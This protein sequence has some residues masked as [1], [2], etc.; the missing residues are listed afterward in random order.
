MP[1]RYP[2][3]LATVAVNGTSAPVSMEG[4]RRHARGEQ[5][6]SALAH[7]SLA[8]LRAELRS[9]EQVVHDLTT[10]RQAL[11][12]EMESIDR[13]LTALSGPDPQL[14]GPRRPR[15][16]DTLVTA[17]TKLLAGRTMSVAEATDAVQQA[18]YQ[19][20]SRHFRTQVNIALIRSGKF[21]RTGRGT[22]T[23]RATEAEG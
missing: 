14:S 13:Q 17:L 23:A 6:R 19:T 16:G 20:A 4:A 5:L 8:D 9:R 7:A 11:T 2:M 21:Q 1:R 10:R 3:P 12:R 18:G 22:Y 15:N